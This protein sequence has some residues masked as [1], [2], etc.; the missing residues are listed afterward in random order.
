[1]WH[2]EHMEFGQHFENPNNALFYGLVRLLTLP[3]VKDDFYAKY[4]DFALLS[5]L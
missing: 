4:V 5:D 2:F 1:M 3:S